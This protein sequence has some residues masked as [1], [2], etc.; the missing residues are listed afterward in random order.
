MTLALDATA[1]TDALVALVVSVLYRG[2]ALPVAW[3]IVPGNQ[4]GAGAP[5]ILRLFAALEPARPAA[6]TVLVLADRG[7]WSPALW[8][9]LCAHGW[10]PLL[11]VHNH[12]IVT[13]RG[14]APRP[15]HTLVSGPGHAWVGRARLGTPKKRRRWCTVLVVWEEGETAPGTL[16][17]SLAPE[18]V[19]VWWYS[20]RVW[21]ELGFR[22][23]KSLGWQWERTRRRD[24]VRAARHWL[25]L[26]VAT[27]WTVADGA[28]V[29]DASRVAVSP[30]RPRAASPVPSAPP[31]RAVSVVASGLAW[32]R[33]HLA[34][35]TLWS[36]L[37]LTPDPRP[38]P[39][40]SLRL[41]FQQSRS[42]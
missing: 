20:L 26:A 33:L 19:G 12:V 36:V 23:P 34:R 28:R 5:H 7:L 6:R 41:T 10:T 39:S 29:D 17:T 31:P 4:P 21:I 15:A 32:L 35:R 1:P 2:T 24:C 13:P 27:L 37:W 14:E 30:A 40:P 42:P 9:T 25:V 3:A 38:A 11:R 16:V 18:A 22:V 8:E